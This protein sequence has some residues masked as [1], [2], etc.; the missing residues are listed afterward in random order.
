MK[1]F[2]H[3]RHIYISIQLFILEVYSLFDQIEKIDCYSV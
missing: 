1:S 3:I 2:E